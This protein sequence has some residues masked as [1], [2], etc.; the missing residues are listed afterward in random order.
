MF[1]TNFTAQQFLSRRTA[2]R[3]KD[4]GTLI[5]LLLGRRRFPNG[6]WGG[7]CSTVDDLHVQ[8]HLVKEGAVLSDAS[9]SSEKFV[10]GIK[11]LMA[12]NYLD[13]LGGSATSS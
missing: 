8:V 13:N 2:S 6:L 3:G 5:Y 11:V 1:K 9:V 10:H 12:K 7:I 4:R